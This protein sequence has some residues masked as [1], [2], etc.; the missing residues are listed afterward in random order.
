VP[1]LSATSWLELVRD[2]ERRGELLGA[3]DLAESG[4]AEQPGDVPLQHRAVLALARAGATAEARRRFKAYRLDSVSDED[5]A[6]LGARIAKDV[7]LSLSGSARKKEAASAARLYGA[8]HTRTAGYYPAINAA[9]L[10]LVA[11]QTERAQTIARDVQ[12]KLTTADDASY[13]VWATKAEA[14]LI[15]G[16]VDAA[17]DALVQAALRHESDFAALATTRRQLRLICELQHIDS[18]VLE[19]LAG[20]SVAHYCGHRIAA[21]GADGR[22]PASAERQV[23]KL[24]DREL[25]RQPVRFAYGA[26]AAGADVLWAEAILSSGGE[27]HVVL[28]FDLDEFVATSVAPSGGGWVARFSACLSRAASVTYGT[29]DAFCADDALF[30]YGAE[31]AMGLAVLRA[32]YLDA[33]VRQLAVWDRASAAGDAGTAIDVARWRQ[34]EWPVIVIPPGPAH[35]SS[36][37]TELARTPAS[38]SAVEASRRVVRALLFADIRGFSKLSDEQLPL[39]AKEVLASFA[40]TLDRHGAAVEHRNTWGDAIY[41][42]V[43]GV[44]RAAACALE[45]QD[46]MAQVDLIRAGLPSHLALRLGAHVGPVFAMRDPVLKAAVFMGSHVSRTARIEPVTPPGEVYVT[47]PF[48]GALALTAQGDLTCDYVGHLPAAKDFGRMRMYRLRRA[49]RYGMSF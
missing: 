30:R 26:L 19:L 9:T 39:F 4:L 10:R 24:I 32:R 21:P 33:D 1:D 45:L 43:R 13:Y 16:E 12:R 49:R 25:A 8:I 42:V 15:L 5:V 36:A 20:P 47:E 41:A 44:S 46:A 6:A 17:G 27:L 38:S 11:G 31:L 18:A 34:T 29:E 23:A 35:R 22:F 2:A 40:R 37:S 14:H 48:A 28:P 7:A 3:V